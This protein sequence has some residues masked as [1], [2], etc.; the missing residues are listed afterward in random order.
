MN[1]PTLASAFEPH[2]AGSGAL[3][4][5]LLNFILFVTVLLSCIAFIEPSPHDAMMFVLLVACVWAHV[6]LD[7]KLAPLILLL[8]MWLVG[9]AIALINVADDQAAV[10]YFGTSVYLAF[11]AVVFAC[12]FSEGDLTR[13][14]L[15]NRAYLIAALVAA[16]AG[17]VGY[18]HLLPG[19]N[20]FLDL[21]G[22]SGEF[23]RVSATFKDPNVY[24]PF[25][26]F[27]LM[28]LMLGFL[29][30]P[31]AIGIV[32]IVTLAGGVLLSYSRGAW[33]HF[34]L[35]VVI[36]IG[37]A[38]VSAPDQRMRTRIV[39]YALI[40]VVGLLILFVGLMSVE[41]IREMLVE[42]AKV[43]QPYD[44]GS[45]GRF[46]LQQLALSV[47]LQ[48]PA[49]LGPLAF[50]NAYGSQQH[51]V[52]LQGFLV[53][54]WIGG[55]AYLTLIAVTL[56]LGLRHVIQRTPWQ[57]YLI[58]AYAT[59]IGQVGE[60]TIIDT[61]HWRHFFLLLGLVWGLSVASINYGRGY[62]SYRPAAAT[63]Y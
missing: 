54:G 22:T 27:P 28:M 1:S 3:A 56:L 61:D 62:A 14:S 31:T 44:T 18:F 38:F 11:A 47:I 45:G 36:A 33:I 48:N 26:I 9:G 43:L 13:L 7:R 51:N 8:I 55:A 50:S 15:M 25:L 49:G 59:F 32:L 42:R 17:Y 63:A 35:S 20:V 41:S 5:R 57:P 53:Y 23:A 24:G 46:T 10:Q 58:A 16:G 52:Y 39:T 40:A 12:L 34:G 19:A 2:R 29:A 6:T 37:L 4:Q 30:R 60:G 21:A